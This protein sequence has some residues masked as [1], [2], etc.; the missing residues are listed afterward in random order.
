MV[1]NIAR[2]IG[3]QKKLPQNLMEI[4]WEL[5]PWQAVTPDAGLTAKSST[6]LIFS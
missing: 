5:K 1:C 6:Y 4:L 3:Q 2:K